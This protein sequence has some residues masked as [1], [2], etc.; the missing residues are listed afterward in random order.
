MVFLLEPGVRL[1][2]LS[3]ELRGDP[4]AQLGGDLEILPSAT[5]FT[6]YVE[7]MAPLPERRR[8]ED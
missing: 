3:Q 6:V 4:G 2:F 8:H 7:E 5:L 1:L